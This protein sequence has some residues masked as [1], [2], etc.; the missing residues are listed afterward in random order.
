MPSDL[1]GH[2]GCAAPGTWAIER[3][4]AFLA[5]LFDAAFDAVF[6]DA[7]GIHNLDLF[8]GALADELG[9]EHPKGRP[10]LLGMR[11]DGSDAGE[12]SPLPI[13]LND[14]NEII[15][16]GSPIGDEGQ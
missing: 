14:A 12:K 7:E 9:R 10:I 16:G 13:F 5:V 4:D 8:T 1:L 3:L 11:K 15:D 2:H 6:R